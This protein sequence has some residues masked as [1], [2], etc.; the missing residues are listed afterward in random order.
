MDSDEECPIFVPINPNPIIHNTLETGITFVDISKQ[1]EATSLP[2]NKIERPEPE[3]N[4]KKRGIQTKGARGIVYRSRLE[5]KY[6]YLW[7]YL[8]WGWDYEP[9]DL[10]GY[11]PDFSVYPTEDISLMVEIKGDL[12]HEFRGALEKAVRGGHSNYCMFLGSRSPHFDK[13]NKVT[14]DARFVSPLAWKDDSKEAWFFRDGFEYYGDKRRR[15]EWI[16]IEDV[17]MK[18]IPKLTK[19]VQMAMCKSCDAI[20]P[21]SRDTCLLCNVKSMDYIALRQN[22]VRAWSEFCNE[23]RWQGGS[24]I[25]ADQ[26]VQVS[27]SF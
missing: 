9:V 24:M 25:V 1:L 18:T 22:I 27:V 7:D 12:V 21:C 20:V 23:T 10:K 11:I 3:A 16:V 14:I 13:S 6:A 2:Y 5:A 19:Q 17:S 8:D 15:T 4:K 26:S